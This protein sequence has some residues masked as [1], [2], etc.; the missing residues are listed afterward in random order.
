MLLDVIIMFDKAILIASFILN[1]HT[2]HYSRYVATF[3]DEQF[4]ARVNIIYVRI[5]F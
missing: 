5:R 1:F 3:E 4:F 2:D